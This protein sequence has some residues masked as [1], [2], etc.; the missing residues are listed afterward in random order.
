MAGTLIVAAFL[1]TQS[2]GS[3]VG[4]RHGVPVF[5]RAEGQR[6]SFV[7]QD[8][9]LKRKQLVHWFKG[10]PDKDTPIDIVVDQETPPRCARQA[11]RALDEADFRD[12]KITNGAAQNYGPSPYFAD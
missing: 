11:L 10:R 3:V 6:C 1:A 2:A 12:I 4:D 7:V 9:I 8:M 5:V